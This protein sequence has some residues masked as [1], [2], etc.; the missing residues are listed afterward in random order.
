MVVPYTKR[1]TFASSN[2]QQRQS[3]SFKSTV[4]VYVVLHLNNYTKEEVKACW[5]SDSEMNEIR[6]DIKLTLQKMRVPTSP[7]SVISEENGICSFG[8]ESFSK[9]GSRRKQ[10]R[11]STGKNAVFDI[12]DRQ[13]EKRGSIYN[14][15]AIAD[16]YAEC[17]TVSKDIARVMGV[18][19]EL[20]FLPLSDGKRSRDGYIFPTISE[21]GFKLALLSANPKDHVLVR[22]YASLAA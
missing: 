10:M 22:K 9:D 7:I 20:A 5:F 15:K 21:V 8:L 4:N 2:G 18:F 16:A 14:A 11:R 17:T 3:V 1:S 12:Q 19:N 13:F 6:A